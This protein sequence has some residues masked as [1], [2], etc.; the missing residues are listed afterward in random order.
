[1]Q[2]VAVIGAGRVGTAMALLLS[3]RGFEVTAVADRSREARQKAAELSGADALEKN[4]DAAALADIVLITVPDSSI[5]GVCDSL[6][7]AGVPLERKKVVHMSGAL[8]LSALASASRAG[9]D[10]LSIH[11]IQ[12]FA[13]LEGATAALP[14]STFGVTCDEGAF[15][16]ASDFVASL[17]GRAIRIDDRDKVAYHAAATV[18]C[19]LMAMVE[20]G[21]LLIARQLGFSDSEE[22]EAFGPLITATAANVARIGPVEALTGPLARGDVDTVRSHLAALEEVGG[23]LA[24]MYRAVCLVGLQMLEE[25]DDCDREAVRALRELLD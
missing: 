8:S 5:E 17:K 10:T 9:A 24:P 16:W 11:P 15:S 7:S 19:N 18:A 23:G 6:V 14:G 22:R 21:A 4:E 25:R 2:K 12:T 3:E 13:D 20:Y 1:M